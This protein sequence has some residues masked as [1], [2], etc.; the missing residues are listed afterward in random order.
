MIRDYGHD[1]ENNS[2]PY[3]C[4]SAAPEPV[5]SSAHRK[6]ASPTAASAAVKAKEKH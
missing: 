1:Y 3:L 2:D 6:S 4:R 5:C